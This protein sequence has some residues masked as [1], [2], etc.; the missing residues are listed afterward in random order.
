MGIEY[1]G[2]Y[3]YL[4]LKNCQKYDHHELVSLKVDVLTFENRKT[5]FSANFAIVSCW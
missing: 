4:K 3:F 5:Y 1:R 2:D